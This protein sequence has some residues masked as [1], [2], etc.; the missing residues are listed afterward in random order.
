[1]DFIKKIG[2]PHLDF[3]IKGPSISNSETGSSLPSTIGT[4][5]SMGVVGAV[6]KGSLCRVQLVCIKG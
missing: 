1:M 5:L 4:Q 6:S 3:T 2:M